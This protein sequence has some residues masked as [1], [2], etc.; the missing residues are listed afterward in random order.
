[1][2]VAMKAVMHVIRQSTLPNIS[3]SSHSKR[4]RLGR[5]AVFLH[6]S[7]FPAIEMCVDLTHSVHRHM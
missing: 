3:S 5:A 2:I 7:L 6:H 1:M 4:R